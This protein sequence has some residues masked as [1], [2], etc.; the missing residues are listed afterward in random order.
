[1]NYQEAID[2]L[3]SQLP[4]Y[5]R[6]GASAYKDNLD[7]TLRMDEYFGHPHRK[8]HSI[9][10]AGTNG[11]GS[12]S[13]MLASILQEA[14][15]R[16]GLYTSPHLIDFRERIKV[17]GEMI[18]EEDVVD[19]VEK[20]RDI[21]ETVQPSFFEM[22]VAMA[23]N[24]FAVQNIDFAVVEVGLGGRLDSTNIITPE[25]SVITNIGLDHVA[26]LGDTLAK[27][28]AEKA[29]IIKPGVPAVIG[30]RHE[31]YDEVFLTKAG[32]NGSPICWAVDCV[33]VERTAYSHA[34][35]TVDIYVE[36]K[37]TY[38]DLRVPL[39][40]IYQLEN[41][42]TVVAAIE[43][44]RKTGSGISAEALCRGIE[45]VITN[46]GLHGRWQVLSEKPLIICDTGH[47]E[48]GIRKVAEQLAQIPAVKK[49]LVIGMVSDKDV[50]KV[51]QLLPKDGVFYFTRASIPR[52]LDPVELRD[53]AGKYGLKGDIYP[54]VKSAVEAAKI[55]CGDNDLIFIGGSTFVVAEVV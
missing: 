14:G 43:S 37:L 52:S 41:I 3:F 11:K 38:K 28:A 47:N 15:Y 54:D 18:R 45:R 35:Q 42:A 40:G 33:K 29:G 36:D 7:N 51:L 4:M 19:F 2:Y 13:H 53:I 49:H 20:S 22:T 9:H 34:F 55:K 39:P 30:R 23:F 32:Q 10:I 21:I 48:D 5:Q 1:M 44:L 50:S 25:L 24:Y 6:S 26:I 27:I 16:T 46:T 12:V 8:F 17:N 31:E